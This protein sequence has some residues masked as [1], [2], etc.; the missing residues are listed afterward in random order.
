MGEKQT[1]K[2]Q[3]LCKLATHICV[4]ALNKAEATMRADYKAVKVISEIPVIVI[5]SCISS[6]YC[7]SS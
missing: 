1:N 4:L 3:G 5:Q 2:Q 6:L 7:L